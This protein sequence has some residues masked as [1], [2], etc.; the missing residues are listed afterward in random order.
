[1]T[2]G[3]TSRRD[4]ARARRD[5]SKS[6]ALRKWALEAAQSPLAASERRIFRDFHSARDALLIAQKR[7][8]GRFKS[9]VSL[10]RHTRAGMLIAPA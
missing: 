2:T 3:A 10:S 5:S 9:D 6:E 1:V 4:S 8:A 7:S